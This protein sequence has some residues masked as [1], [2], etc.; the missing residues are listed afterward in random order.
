MNGLGIKPED[1]IILTEEVEVVINNAASVNFNDPIHDALNIN[2]FGSLRMQDLAR[3]CKNLICMV[4]VSSTF[5]NCNQPGNKVVPEA[6]AECKVDTES[7]INKI[8]SMNPQQLEVETPSVL[9]AFGF[10]NT[11]TFSKHMAEHMLKK[12]AGNMKLSIVRPSSILGCAKEPIIGWV[13]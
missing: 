9:S 4:H 10:P 11:Y 12:R 7:Y 6:L 8:L 5:V 13:D 1:R 3:E 2:Y